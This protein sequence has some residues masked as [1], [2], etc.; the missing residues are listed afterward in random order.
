MD[1]DN[2]LTTIEATH[3]LMVNDQPFSDIMPST[4]MVQSELE[5]HKI[6][7]TFPIFYDYRHSR[8]QHLYAVQKQSTSA[9]DEYKLLKLNY[10]KQL[11]KAAFSVDHP[12]L[13]AYDDP[14]VVGLFT[15]TRDGQR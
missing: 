14:D 10:Q 4:Q 11:N 1:E 2:Y 6:D 3:G 9:A 15:L 8:N 7:T 12:F 5:Q 13:S